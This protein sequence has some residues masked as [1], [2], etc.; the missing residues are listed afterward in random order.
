[1]PSKRTCSPLMP[2]SKPLGPE[3]KAEDLLS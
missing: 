2:P 3:S 1:L